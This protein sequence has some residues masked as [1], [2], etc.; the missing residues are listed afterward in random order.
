MVVG[1]AL[2]FAAALI[3]SQL[4][5]DSP[6]FVI[7][8]A[9]I[10]QGFGFG[11]SMMPN[12]VTGLNSLPGR[13]VAQ[14]TSVRQLNVRVMAS[15]GVALLATI[16]AI[17]LGDMTTTG[18]EV[19]GSAAARDVYKTVFGAMAISAGIATALGFFLHGTERNRQLQAER[20]AEYAAAEVL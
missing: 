11:F 2:L 16:L 14:A 15:F 18:A 8:L 6:I 3:L 13:F 5:I 12:S 20:A 9:L 4:E 17:Q 10:L 1:S 7:E 19:A